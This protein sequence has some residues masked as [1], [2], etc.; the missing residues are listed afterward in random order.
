M[1]LNE[2]SKKR[3]SVKNYLKKKPD[4]DLIMQAIETAN[5]APSPGNLPILKYII[6]EDPEKIKRISE[7]CEQEFINDAPYVVIF[8]SDSG[9]I[10]NLYENRADKYIKQQAGAAIENF[11]LKIIELKL[12]TCWVGAFSDE[13]LKM[14]LKIPDFIEVEALFPIGYESKTHK[15]KQK[16]K[17]TLD[18]RIFFESYGNNKQLSYVKAPRRED[19]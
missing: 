10:K 1:K 2:L 17:P 15:T 14:E 13:V 8:C 12:A 5:L 19:F 18:S 16:P 6:I 4:I 9:N 3:A 11:L 7:C